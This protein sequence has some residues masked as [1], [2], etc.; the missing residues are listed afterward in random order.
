MTEEELTKMAILKAQADDKIKE[1]SKFLHKPEVG[2]LGTKTEEQTPEPPKKVD[3]NEYP[4]KVDFGSKSV[5]FKAWTGRTRKKVQHI[6]TLDNITDDEGYE[7]L[8]EILIRDH[9][10]ERDIY[11]S[12]TEMQYLFLKIREESY[13]TSYLAE[14]ECPKCGNMQEMK[15]T[16]SCIKPK[17]SKFP[18]E[19]KELDCRIV[20]IKTVTEFKK[21]TEATLKAL[22]DGITTATDIEIIMH[23]ENNKSIIERLDW[24]DELNLKDIK[25]LLKKINEAAFQFDIV[26]KC[27]CAEC[28]E[29]G[30]FET[31]DM[32]DFLD[33]LL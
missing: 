8:V 23:I 31:T 18:L 33:E 11:L 21:T 28:G 19:V 27:T 10:S 1:R 6:S 15:V 24:F 32:P 22:N 3:L 2:P 5:N 12:E 4:F 14:G 26:K 25:M 13:D 9:I 29:E 20:D 16:P 17:L 30:M 7:K